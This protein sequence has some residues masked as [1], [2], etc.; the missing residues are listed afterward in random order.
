[1]LIWP[2]NSVRHQTFTLLREVPPGNDIWANHKV[3]R[4]LPLASTGGITNT[5]T[6]AMLGAELAKTDGNCQ[7]LSK[8]GMEKA[9]EHDAL[10]DMDEILGFEVWL[11]FTPYFW[12]LYFIPPQK[13]KKK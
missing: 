10:P 5:R 1:M 2:N 3:M 12:L 4:S 11:F 6:L 7:F 8:S 9:L 13:K